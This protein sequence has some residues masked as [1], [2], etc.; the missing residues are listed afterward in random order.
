MSIRPSQDPARVARARKSTA[1]TVASL[2]TLRYLRSSA[3]KTRLVVDQIRG[4]RVDEARAL[5]KTS[6][7]SVA[8]DVLKLLMSA[9]ANTENRP[10][11]AGMID[12]DELYV[13]RAEVGEGPAMKRIQPAPMGRAYPIRK[14]T[15]H[16]TL[17]LGSLGAPKKPA[18]RGGRAARAKTAKAPT[19]DAADAASKK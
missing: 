18:A 3:Q 8:R 5:L 12:Q 14:R 7:K 1:L 9:V 10:E 11:A 4:K 15:C 6:R 17:E 19:R 13:T 16:V 2:A